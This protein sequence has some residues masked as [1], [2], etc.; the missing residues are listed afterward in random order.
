MPST[1]PFAAPG[2]GLNEERVRPPTLRGA[3]RTEKKTRVE[4]RPTHRVICLARQPMP[5]GGLLNYLI[6]QA[7]VTADTTR[8]GSPRQAPKPGTVERSTDPP[9][10]ARRRMSEIRDLYRPSLATLTDLYELTMRSE[11]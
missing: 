5:T 10:H 7:Q 6:E 3:A 11:E 9:T 1:T 4:C 8:A 2:I